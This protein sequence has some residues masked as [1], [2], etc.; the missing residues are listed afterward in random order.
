MF[1]VDSLPWMGS[2]L[3]RMVTKVGLVV[4]VE[5]SGVPIELTSTLFVE[6]LPGPA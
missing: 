6:R 4:C 2:A 3:V 5:L 1:E